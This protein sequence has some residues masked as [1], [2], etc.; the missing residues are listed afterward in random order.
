MV[1][2]QDPAH[3]SSQTHWIYSYIRNNSLSQKSGNELSPSYTSAEWANST[4]KWWERLSH[5]L[6]ISPT[7]G[8]VT[9]NRKGT[10]NAQLPSEEWR[11][12]PHIRHPNFQ[13]S[14]RSRGQV[15]CSPK[16]AET[17]FPGSTL[18]SS[19]S[20]GSHSCGR[21]GRLLI[22][23]TANGRRNPLQRPEGST[24]SVLCPR[25]TPTAGNSQKGA[26]AHTG[27]PGLAFFPSP[28]VF[29][30]ISFSCDEK[31]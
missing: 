11:V 16:T 17:L 3:T 2:Q 5:N 14:H 26:C 6:T 9:H 20:Q 29:T 28:Y 1:T 24:V 19:R 22:N 7:P 12:E 25:L 21:R 31:F 10:H 18:A 8:A 4:S 13:H 27:S 15:K 30:K 23:H